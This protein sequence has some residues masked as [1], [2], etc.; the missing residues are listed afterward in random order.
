VRIYSKETVYDATIRRLHWIYDEFPNVVVSVSGGKDSTV[1]FEMTLAVARERG[2]LPLNVMWI[3]QEAEW[4][5]TV[6]QNRYVMYH[7]DVKPYWMQIPMKLFNATSGGDNWLNCWRSEDEAK[8]IHPQDPISIKENRYGSDRFS[9]LFNNIIGVEFAAQKTANIGGV[10]AE[11]SPSRLVSLTYRPKY[12]WV[13]WGKTFDQKL[14]HYTFYPIYDWSYTDVWKAIHQHE[15]RY[16]EVYDTMYRFGIPIP[17]MRVSNVHH[18]TA[19]KQLFFLQEFEPHTYSRL[20]DRLDGIDMAGKLGDD[21]YFVSELPFMF[22]DWPEYRDYLLENLI[23]REDWRENLRKKFAN[24]DQRMGAVGGERMYKS[25]VQSI[26]THDWEGIKIKN[27]RNM[28]AI[29]GKNP[30]L[31]DRRSGKVPA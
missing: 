29:K 20:C 18:E 26:L 1:I 22:K 8:W 11:E 13:T 3:D 10:R 4:E 17:S 7:P 28:M 5:S 14:E 6:E 19:V 15:W 12:K 27:F 23:E 21:D 16:N 25:H 2:R 31:S 30:P 9:R 24:D